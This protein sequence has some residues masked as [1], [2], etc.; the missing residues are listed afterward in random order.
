MQNLLGTDP[1][2]P[3]RF[4]AVLGIALIPDLGGVPVPVVTVPTGGVQLGTVA[5]PQRAGHRQNCAQAATGDR[6]RTSCRDDH[7]EPGD[8]PDHLVGRPG[9]DDEQDATRSHVTATGRHQRSS[10]PAGPTSFAASTRASRRAPGNTRQWM[11][12]RTLTSRSTHQRARAYDTARSGP[13]QS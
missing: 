11:E 9:T 2:A 10:S 3:A 8:V 7:V 6:V 4:A 13:S 12:L 1:V 5:R